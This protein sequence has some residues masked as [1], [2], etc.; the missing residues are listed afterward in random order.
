MVMQRTSHTTEPIELAQ[1]GAEALAIA[2]DSVFPLRDRIESLIVHPS[3]QLANDDKWT[4]FEELSTQVQHLLISSQDH[5]NMLAQYLVATDGK[6]PAMGGYTLIRT[7]I[8]S[9][10]LA[11]WLLAGGTLNKRVLNSLT[12]ARQNAWDLESFAEKGGVGS[13]TY[14]ET[15][16]TMLEKNKNAR[17]P[18]RQRSIPRMP[19]WSEIVEGS[20]V[21]APRHPGS[22]AIQVW[23]A[24]SGVA[25]SNMALTH[26]LLERRT[27][28]GPHGQPG[29][30]LSSKLSTLAIF[31]Q[32]ALNHL[33]YAIL[34]FEEA[35]A[36][37]AQG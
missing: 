2:L 27:G 30:R 26:G 18:L 13:E 34:R 24:C 4:P 16:Q 31:T 9:A 33:N 21:H 36:A 12:L 1:A 32:V 5:L 17:G 28:T 11:I 22:T 7:S 20:G 10:A 15:V 23:K 37:R 14:L 6:V 29:F 19:K 35:A 8:E 3:S 25:H